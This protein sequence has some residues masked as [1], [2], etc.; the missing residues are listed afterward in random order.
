MDL[1]VCMAQ[2]KLAGNVKVFTIPALVEFEVW[3]CV[4]GFVEYCANDEEYYGYCN[5]DFAFRTFS[6][7]AS[8]FII[9]VSHLPFPIIIVVVSWSCMNELAD[10]I[11]WSESGRQL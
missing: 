5:V 8:H 3:N 4:S 7:A 9:H 6:K 10:Y 11:F 1:I 2:K